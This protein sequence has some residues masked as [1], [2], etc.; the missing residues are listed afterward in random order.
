MAQKMMYCGM[1]SMT[2]PTPTPTKKATHGQ[3]QQMFS[4][5]SDDDLFWF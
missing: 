4:E 1:K 3:I 5:E 2:N